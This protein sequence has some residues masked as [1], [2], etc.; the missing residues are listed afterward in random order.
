VA[1][2][3]GLIR[4]INVGGNK[5]VKMADLRELLSGMGF[6]NPR[7]LLQSGNFV[8][9][10]DSKSTNELESR[11]EAEAEVKLGLRAAFFVRSLNQWDSVIAN[12]PYPDG[13]KSDP[14]HLLAVIGKERPEE[15]LLRE[16]QERFP[17]TEQIAVSHGNLYV[18]APD[19]IGTSKLLGASAWVKATSTGTARNWNTVLA[20][21]KLAF[22]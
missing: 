20:L 4:G 22:E 7:T 16:L 5:K 12:N 3:I 11:L 1:T 15:K 6:E 14:S 10:S 17:G 8:F 19:G 2:Y 13:A 18:F 9:G 21:Q